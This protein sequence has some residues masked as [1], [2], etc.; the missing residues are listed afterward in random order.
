LNQFNNNFYNFI[1]REYFWFKLINLPK[2]IFAL[3][4]LL[5]VAGFYIKSKKN[6]QIKQQWEIEEQSEDLEQL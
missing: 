4:P 6:K 3:M 5:L 1:K 2:N